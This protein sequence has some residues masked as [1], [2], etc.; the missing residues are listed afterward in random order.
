MPETANL[1]AGGAHHGDDESEG[2]EPEAAGGTATAVA[3]APAM[4]EV[5]I[6]VSPVRAPAEDDDDGAVG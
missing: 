2:E 1:A 4:L 6:T 5:P 3:A